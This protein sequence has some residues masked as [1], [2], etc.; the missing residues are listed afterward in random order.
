MLGVFS[1]SIKKTEPKP[2]LTTR[3]LIGGVTQSVG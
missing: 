1:S 2:I 3:A